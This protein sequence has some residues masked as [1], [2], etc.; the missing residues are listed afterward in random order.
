[1]GEPVG[2]PRQDPP[3]IE[4][5]PIDTFSFRAPLGLRWQRLQIPVRGEREGA[6]LGDEAADGTHGM[7]D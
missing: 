7:S 6:S 3:H 5:G 4:Y 2:S 1:M